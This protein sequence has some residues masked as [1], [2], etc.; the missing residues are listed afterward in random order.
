MP[1][2]DLVIEQSKDKELVQLKDRLQSERMSPSVASKYIILDNI[3]YY[4]CYSDSDP[5]IRLYITS[6]LKQLVI[7]QNHDMDGHM[8]IEKTYDS[9]KGKYYWPNMYKEL[10]QHVNLCVICQR[11][12]LRKVKPPLQETDAPPFPFAKLG[13]DVSGPYPTTLSGCKCIISFVDWFSG[14]PE[15]FAVPDKSAETVVHLVLDRII[16]RHSTVLQIV[17][18][19]GTENINKVMKYT[20]EQMNISHATTSYYHP[21]GNSKV[22]IFHRT[23]HDVMSQ[24]VSENVET[25]D[26]YLNQV[27]A[28]IKFNTNDSTKF[29]PFYL[30]YNH[31]LLLPI[32]NILQPRHRYCG[33]ETHRIGLQQQHKSFL[34][35]H[36]HLKKAKDKTGK[37]C[38]QQ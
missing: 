8:G 24:R 20:L 9:I 25:W 11:R 4:L 23:L 34:L 10:Y 30:L 36:R 7:E 3:L 38:Q 35:V 31:D 22:E 33:E 26:I 37:V 17:T 1:G 6:H 27:L 29:F 32:D 19:N 18:D 14:W 2:F 12:N 15:A 5:I 16:P 13:L 28:A 21:Q